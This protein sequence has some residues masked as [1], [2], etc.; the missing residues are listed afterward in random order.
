MGDRNERFELEFNGEDHEQAIDRSEFLRRAGGTVLATSLAGGLVGGDAL[1]G[2]FTGA[3]VP[4]HP[5]DLLG[6]K[7]VR[8]KK[9]YR[10]GLN[11]PQFRDPYW[12]SVAYG[13]SDEARRW[14]T[15]M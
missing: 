7:A 10:L 13:A 9:A 14:G 3:A 5:Q 1:A 11:V 6:L 4:T 12:V 8:P 15:T 2:M